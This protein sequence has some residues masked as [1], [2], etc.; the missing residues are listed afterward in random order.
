MIYLFK[1]HIILNSGK[2]PVV[3]GCEHCQPGYTCEPSTGACIRGKR[4]NSPT[5][6]Y[7]VCCC[8]VYVILIFKYKTINKHLTISQ[9]RFLPLNFVIRQELHNSFI[10]STYPESSFFFIII[11]FNFFFFYQV[12]GKSFLCTYIQF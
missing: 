6:Q 12:L 9:Q 8:F 11:L 3:T 2:V 10:I 5:F 7:S 4:E 1:F